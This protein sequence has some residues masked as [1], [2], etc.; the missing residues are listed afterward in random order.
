MK[1]A[2]PEATLTPAQRFARAELLRHMEDLQQLIAQRSY[3]TVDELVGR[4]ADNI[5]D[6]GLLVEYRARN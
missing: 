2:A 4:L 5:R 1:T 6:C 3:A